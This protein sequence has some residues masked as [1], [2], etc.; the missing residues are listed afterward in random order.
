M[1]SAQ[2][3]YKTLAYS[4]LGSISEADDIAQEAELVRLQLREKPNNPEAYMLRVVTNLALDRLRQLKRERM[5][6]TGPWLPEPATTETLQH[7]LERADQLSLGFMLL[8]ERLSPAERAVFVL[9]ELFEYSLQDI[10]ELL[11]ISAPATRQRYRR[12]R[13][14]LQGVKR[15]AT[16]TRQQYEL[17][18]QLIDS[19]EQQDFERL[20]RLLAED[21]VV[22]TD[23]G[24]VVS[25]A[26]IPLTGVRRVAQVLL[27]LANKSRTESNARWVFKQGRAELAL[28]LYA[29]N[30]LDG[31]MTL[32]GSERIERIYLVRNP[33]K[34]SHLV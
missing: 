23:G 11:G 9:R 17:L 26:L 19:V 5:H 27:F 7:T 33:H 8:L 12:A 31:Y 13:Q 4:L 29:D 24:G 32:E 2:A 18:Q 22:L 34:L 6:Y 14:N 3:R 16:P 1:T 10:S 21:V 30:Q 25:A 15:F 20:V 28:L